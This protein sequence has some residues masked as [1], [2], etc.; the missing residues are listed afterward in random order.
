[1]NSD[2]EFDRIVEAIDANL[3]YLHKERWAQRA[4]ELREEEAQAEGDAKVR[5]HQALRDHYADRFKPE[6]SRDALVAQARINLEAR[7]GT[8][9]WMERAP[10]TMK[11]LATDPERLRS[12]EQRGF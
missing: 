1:M 11:Q 12:I 4:A 8:Q 2:P 5:A 9:A 6:T 10:E 3:D 7:R